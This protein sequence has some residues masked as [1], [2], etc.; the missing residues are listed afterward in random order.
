M[1]VSHVD[2]VKDKKYCMT[3]AEYIKKINLTTRGCIEFVSLQDLKGSSNFGGEYD[4][5]D[6]VADINW[7][8]LVLDEAHE[9]VD[10]EK[11]DI[12]L[13]HIKRRFTL[14]L[15][16][17]PFKML[18]NEQFPSNAIFNWTYADEQSRK[19]EKKYQDM[20]DASPY[21]SLPRLNL[22]TYQMSEVI[23]EVVDLG[24]EIDDD[25]Y[26]Y[27]FDLNEFFKTKADGTFIHDLDVD[28]FLDAM[29]EQTKYPFS[30]AEL[31]NQ[32]KHTFWLL[33][34]IDSAKALKEKLQNHN[35]FKSY[36]IILAAGSGDDERENKSAIADVKNSI[37][38]YEKTITLSVGQ[39]T[40]GVTIPE[41]TAVMMLCNCKSPALYMQAA[42]RAQNPCMFT[43]NGNSYRKENAYVFDFDPARTLDIFEQFAN[44]L[45][46]DTAGAKGDS[47]TRKQH[48]RELLNFFPVIGEDDDG[49]MIELDAEPAGQGAWLRRPGPGRFERFHERTLERNVSRR[50]GRNAA[51]GRVYPVDL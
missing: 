34:R 25:R 44:N 32:L 48:V 22:F 3:R 40:T 8:V 23:G 49:E 46:P 13:D 16:G 24:A 33:D 39:L 36:H 11:T 20:G 12:A 18:A 41:W 29:T 42:F 21:A 7:D 50:V 47:D 45:S 30:T 27:F 15:S 5:L 51:R 31:R 4:K 6:E 28:K 1:F 43:E 38:Q 2:A 17:T 9:G 19:R 37:R 10:T 26:A 14:N 35:I